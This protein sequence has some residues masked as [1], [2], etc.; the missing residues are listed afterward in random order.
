M[1]VNLNIQTEKHEN[2]INIPQAVIIERG[3][4]YF[5]K[6]LEGDEIKEREVK[7]GLFGID[8]VEVL[9]GLKEGDKIIFSAK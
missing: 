7:L 4:K 3:D 2:V 9:D 1:T 8:N 5:V 6:I